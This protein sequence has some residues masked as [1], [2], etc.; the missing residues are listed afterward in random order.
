VHDDSAKLE[1]ANLGEIETASHQA[2]N[3]PEPCFTSEFHGK[4][5]S[6]T[7]VPR[8]RRPNLNS[9]QDDV[10]AQRLIRR[11]AEISKYLMLEDVR[12]AP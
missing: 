3:L 1:R 11:N 6:W 7:D 10:A 5:D 2:P 9:V 8:S 12:T 4:R